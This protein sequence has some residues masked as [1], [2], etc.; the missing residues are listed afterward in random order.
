MTGKGGVGNTQR[1]PPEL[2]PLHLQNT[3]HPQRS[4]KA[5]EGEGAKVMGEGRAGAKEGEEPRGKGQGPEG[6]DYFVI[7]L[8]L[9]G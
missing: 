8:F 1:P 2:L 3:S 4:R 7:I 9:K 6:V 5:K